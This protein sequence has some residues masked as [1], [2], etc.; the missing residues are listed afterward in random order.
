VLGDTSVLK[1]SDGN[2]AS[3]SDIAKG[4]MLAIT[5]DESG[6]ITAVVVSDASAQ[7][8][9]PGSAGQSSSSASGAANETGSAAETD[10]SASSE[11]TA[12]ETAAAK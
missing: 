3:L 12:S 11:T 7:G 5:T 8:G 6:N 2:N 10:S 9:Q 4:K 1:D